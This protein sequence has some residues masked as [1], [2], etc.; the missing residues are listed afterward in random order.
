MLQSPHMKKM[1]RSLGFAVEGVTHAFTHERNVRLY[2]AGYVVVILLAIFVRLLTW[3]WLAIIL[4]GGMFFAV[5]LLNTALERLTD[6]IDENRKITG[7]SSFHMGLKHTKDVAAGASLVC[8]TMNII[9]IGLVFWPYC[10]MLIK[11]I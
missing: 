8:L 7:G 3:E 2:F 6:V 5:E 1:K 11:N 9:V 10:L 4:S